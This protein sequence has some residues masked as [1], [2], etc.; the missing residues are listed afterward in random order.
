MIEDGK[1][2]G[3]A[4]VDEELD[5]ALVGAFPIRIKHEFHA[6][7]ELGHEGILGCSQGP[8]A[9]GVDPGTHVGGTTTPRGIPQTRDPEGLAKGSRHAAAQFTKRDGDAE[10]AS[11]D[12]H[13]TPEDSHRATVEKAG[14]QILGT[15]APGTENAKGQSE[16]APDI[17][18]AGER[19]SMAER[20]KIAR[21]Q[22]SLVDS[23]E[24]VEVRL[25]A[26]HCMGFS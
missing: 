3:D 10:V 18:L 26:V 23:V 14:R 7:E 8:P 24:P 9:K 12:E 21:V 22:G 17:K 13:E 20:S 1:A 15:G 6:K 4:D 2:D 25:V 5:P 19:L 16:H 11:E